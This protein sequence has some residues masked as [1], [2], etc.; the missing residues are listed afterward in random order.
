MVGCYTCAMKPAAF[1][2]ACL[3]LSAP[4]WASPPDDPV[5]QKRALLQQRGTEALNRER[6]RSKAHLCE[7]GPDPIVADCW[8][9]EGKAT[10][11]DYAAYVRAIGALLRLPAPSV[12]SPPLP[13]GPPSRPIKFDAAEAAWRGAGTIPP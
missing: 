2:L 1:L 3:S 8:V 12:R 13:D 4:T 6:E 5:Q 7:A 10:D 11:A 9:R